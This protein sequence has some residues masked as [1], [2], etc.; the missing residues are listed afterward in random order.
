M[1]S[2]I[3]KA[4]A[5]GLARDPR[6]H[7]SSFD[8]CIASLT[9]FVVYIGEVEMVVYSAEAVMHRVATTTSIIVLILNIL[10]EKV[11]S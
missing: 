8:G 2:A 10:M 11:L 6:I 4:V 5:E 3:L 7:S 9:S 1:G